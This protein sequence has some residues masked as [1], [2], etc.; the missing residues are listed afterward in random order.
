M[1]WLSLHRAGMGS[2]VLNT[3]LVH[4]QTEEMQ[5]SELWLI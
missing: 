2:V 1:S 4:A 5:M 3:S